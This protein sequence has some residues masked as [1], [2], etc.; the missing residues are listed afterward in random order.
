MQVHVQQDPVQSSLICILG[1]EDIINLMT[2]EDGFQG[3]QNPGRE[4]SITITVSR[5]WLPT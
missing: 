3:R 1:D 5:G 4:S 2:G